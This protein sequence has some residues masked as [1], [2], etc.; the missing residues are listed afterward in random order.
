MDNQGEIRDSYD[1]G[2]ADSYA[3]FPNLSGLPS[4][5]DPFF[6][7]ELEGWNWGAFL[8]NWLW[9]MQV[10]SL[11]GVIL[12]IVSCMSCGLFAIAPAIYLGLK[13]NE[14]AWKHRSFK[15]VEEFRE[16]QAAWTKWAIISY[17]TV[18]AIGIFFAAVIF[19]IVTLVPPSNS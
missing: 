8:L 9:L 14:L 6:L 4:G 7:P 11:W 5:N 16:V 19:M 13:G 1:T 2:D 10:S 15:G 17:A 18:L 12:L 3:G